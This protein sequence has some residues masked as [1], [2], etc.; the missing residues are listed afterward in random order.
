MKNV[1]E[2]AANLFY[3]VNCF[4]LISNSS[5]NN[6]RGIFKAVTSYNNQNNGN[7]VTRHK[8]FPESFTLYLFSDY[9]RVEMVFLIASQ[10]KV[11]VVSA[12]IA[13][14]CRAGV[15]EGPALSQ[16]S[17]WALGHAP[18][19]AHT[20]HRLPGTP[21]RVAVTDFGKKA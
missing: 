19:T 6:K 18:C 15:R 8:G 16:H 5:K 17:L 4:I 9:M 11:E 1:S 3:A 21:Q 12:A 2:N 7:I 10:K 13:G 14:R 20:T